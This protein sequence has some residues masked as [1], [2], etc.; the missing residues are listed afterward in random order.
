MSYNNATL[1]NVPL[2]TRYQGTFLTAPRP[3]VIV[4]V[5]QCHEV[6]VSP[7]PEVQVLKLIA[8]AGTCGRA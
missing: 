4:V 2:S 3:C 8:V 7:Y 1:L 6:N 5:T